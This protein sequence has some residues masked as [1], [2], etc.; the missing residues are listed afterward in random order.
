V[1]SAALSIL[2]A[3]GSDSGHR[4]DGGGGTGGGGGGG[5]AAADAPVDAPPSTAFPISKYP[6]GD[7]GVF[8]ALS[9]GSHLPVLTGVQGFHLSEIQVRLPGAVVGTTTQVNFELDYVIPALSAQ[10][11]QQLSALDFDPGTGGEA[12]RDSHRYVFYFNQFT[13]D[14]LAGQ[15]CHVTAFVPSAPS[16]GTADLTLTLDPSPCVD[17]GVSVLCPDGGVP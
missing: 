4:P 8:I 5:D 3:C 12:F 10:P 1:A 16:L 11:T 13:V 15:S 6:R 7:G 17:T 2:L 14:Q 9:N